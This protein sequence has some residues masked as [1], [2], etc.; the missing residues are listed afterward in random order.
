MDEQRCFEQIADEIASGRVDRKVW[1]KALALAEFD[2]ARARAIYAR[3][4][5]DQLG[6]G[7]VAVAG[8]V[9]GEPAPEPRPFS[10]FGRFVAWFG[11]ADRAGH[12]RGDEADRDD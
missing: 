3:L 8:A 6:V 5:N 10:W 4:R 1:A 9:A 12:R 11:H 7:G 2:A